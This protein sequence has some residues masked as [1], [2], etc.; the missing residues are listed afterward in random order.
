M[1]IISISADGKKVAVTSIPATSRLTAGELPITITIDDFNYVDYVLQLNLNT[2]PDTYAVPH[3]LKIDGNV[4]GITVYVGAGTTVSG[5]I[6][7]QGR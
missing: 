2:S 3:D 1:T 5:E 7:T 6:I 4:V